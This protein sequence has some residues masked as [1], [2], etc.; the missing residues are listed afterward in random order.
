MIIDALLHIVQILL[1]FYNLEWSS[2]NLSYQLNPEYTA[3]TLSN[4]TRLLTEKIRH[5]RQLFNHLY[6]Q[7]S[8]HIDDAS[9]VEMQNVLHEL[10]DM[11]PIN[12]DKYA[13]VWELYSS[14]NG[15]GIVMTT[16]KFHFK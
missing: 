2:I 9:R 8:D 14:F 15:R 3:S 12:K 6:L 1:A 11:Y 7:T 10:E 5:H 16:G 13:S 4:D